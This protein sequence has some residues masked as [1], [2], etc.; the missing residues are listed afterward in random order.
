MMAIYGI[1][2]KVGEINMSN[3]NEIKNDNKVVTRSGYDANIHKRFYTFHIFRRSYTIYLLLGL[4][5]FVL[6][7]AIKNTITYKSNP[8]ASQTT[9]LA[10][11]L[12]ASMTILMTPM[13]MSFR[14]FSSVRKEKKERGDSIEV[15]EFTKDKVLRKIE[16]GGKFVVGWYNIDG[17]YEV[18]DAFYFYITDDM[19]LV[20][21]KDSIIEGDV[22]TLRKLITRNLKPG[23]KGKIPYKKAYKGE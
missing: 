6:Y 10:I 21:K 13:I 1:I 2:M 7:I 5:A 23:K 18:K 19:G 22:E 11:W 9:L 14:V 12:I 15:L 3:K 4:A 17:V 16:N 20:V 8:E